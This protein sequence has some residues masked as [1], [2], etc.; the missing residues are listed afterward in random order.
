[1]CWYDVGFCFGFN[2]V[3]FGFVVCGL[4]DCGLCL[5]LLGVRFHWRVVS[6]LV[7]VLFLVFLVFVDL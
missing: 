3:Y 4:H 2:V 5:G 6:G 1:M 7:E